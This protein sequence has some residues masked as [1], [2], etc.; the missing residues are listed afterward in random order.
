MQYVFCF[1]RFQKLL[2]VSQGLKEKQLLNYSQVSVTKME[3]FVC[4]HNNFSKCHLIM[5]FHH[6]ELK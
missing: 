3:L 6:R 4:F 5:R 2:T 1:Y